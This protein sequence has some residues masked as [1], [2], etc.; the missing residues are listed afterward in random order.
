M[1]KVVKLS[2]YKKKKKREAGH[3][4]GKGPAL[5]PFWMAAGVFALAVAVVF[6]YLIIAGSRP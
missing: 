2:E 6:V 3:E 5:S 1:K 4:H